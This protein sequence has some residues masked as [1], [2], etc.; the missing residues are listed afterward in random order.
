MWRYHLEPYF[1]YHIHKI[2][3]I[4]YLEN[5]NW[6]SLYQKVENSSL[7]HCWECQDAPPCAIRARYSKLCHKYG[8]NYVIW[9]ES[10]ESSYMIVRYVNKISFYY[11]ITSFLFSLSTLL[12][13]LALHAKG[14][15]FLRFSSFSFNYYKTG[16]EWSTWLFIERSWIFQHYHRFHYVIS[17]MY[18]N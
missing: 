6:F 17:N 10:Y 5:E 2:N 1:L 9:L 18:L 3:L 16:S 14:I 13:I 11:P 15:H 12:H 4:R 7:Q 8:H